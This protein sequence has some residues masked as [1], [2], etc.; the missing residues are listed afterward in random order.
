[1][2]LNDATSIHSIEISQSEIYK[3]NIFNS[4]GVVSK[5]IVFSGG[6]KTQTHMPELFSDIELNEIAVNSIEII[7]SEYLLHLDDSIRIIKKKIIHELGQDNIAYEEIYMFSMITETLNMEKI[8]KNIVKLPRNNESNVP[9]E[10]VKE[11]F[12]QFIQNLNIPI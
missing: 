1:M 5:I 11:Q 12:G 7:F 4:H 2:E 9:K 3:I 10:F 6:M 8:F